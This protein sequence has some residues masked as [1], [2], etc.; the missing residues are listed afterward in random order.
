MKSKAQALAAQFKKLNANLEGL[1]LSKGC[2]IGHVDYMRL[3]SLWSQGKVLAAVPVEIKSQ[4]DRETQ[5]KFAE[6]TRL[7][8]KDPKAAMAQALEWRNG[9]CG[10]MR[11]QLDILQ[12]RWSLADKTIQN[13]CAKV[14]SRHNVDFITMLDGGP[15][16]GADMTDEVLQYLS[17]EAQE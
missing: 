7:E 4:L 12:K 14:A 16:Q 1:L 8:R 2:S 3:I 6:L 17:G 15:N 13:A 9:L 5:Q 11:N 10:R